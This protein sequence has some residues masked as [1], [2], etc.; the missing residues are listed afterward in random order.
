MEAMDIYYNM[1]HQSIP[2]Y[3]DTDVGRLTLKSGGSS[4]GDLSSR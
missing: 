2:V 1:V 3:Q 4:T